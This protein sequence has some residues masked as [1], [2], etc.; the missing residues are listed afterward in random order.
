MFEGELY[1]YIQKLTDVKSL[2]EIEKKMRKFVKKVTF[3][4]ND[5]NF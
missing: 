4:W 3:L 2:I 1:I 5:T